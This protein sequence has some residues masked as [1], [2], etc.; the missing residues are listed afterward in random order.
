MHSGCEQ[1]T[2]FGDKVSLGTIKNLP[3]FEKIVQNTALPSIALREICQNWVRNVVEAA[4]EE[5]LLLH[6]VRGFMNKLP[7]ECPAK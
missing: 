5:R 4:I 7:T 1:S 6:S 3:E 2:H